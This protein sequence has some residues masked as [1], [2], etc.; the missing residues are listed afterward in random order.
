MTQHVAVLMGGWS[1]EREV[2]LVTGDAVCAALLDAANHAISDQI[3]QNRILTEA[4]HV[5]AAL[6]AGRAV[7]PPEPLPLVASVQ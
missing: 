3:S 4:L 5:A 6:R 2:S 1:A 7:A